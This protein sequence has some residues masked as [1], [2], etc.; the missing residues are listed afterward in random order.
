MEIIGLFAQQ[1]LSILSHGPLD[2]LSTPCGDMRKTK[3]RPPR[4][5]VE[6]LKGVLVTDVDNNLEERLASAKSTIIFEPKPL[7]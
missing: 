3:A 2:W 4:F 5:T 6:I 7:T 1:V